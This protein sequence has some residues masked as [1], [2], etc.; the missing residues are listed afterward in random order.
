MVENLMG[1]FALREFKAFLRA[2]GAE[3][4]QTHGAGD[5][6]GRGANAATGAVN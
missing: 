4:G 3:D 1:A 5:L 2:G 6:H